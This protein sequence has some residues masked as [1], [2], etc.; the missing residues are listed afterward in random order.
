M[1]TKLLVVGRPHQKLADGDDLGQSRHGGELRVLVG[2]DHDHDV[3]I[4][5]WIAS[6]IDELTGKPLERRRR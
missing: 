4:Q 6:Q 5:T 3:N 1:P 2:A